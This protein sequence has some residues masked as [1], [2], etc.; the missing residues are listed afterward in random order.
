MEDLNNK[1]QKILIFGGAF[2]PPHITL[3]TDEVQ[4]PIVSS[5]FIRQAISQG[6]SGL[7]YVSK[8]VAEFIA[9]HRLY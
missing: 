2:N 1:K 6:A 7:P 8:A 3:L 9:R 5:T 4:T